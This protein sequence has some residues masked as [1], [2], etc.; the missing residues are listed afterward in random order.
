[1]EIQAFDLLVSFLG[2]GSFAPFSVRSALRF[3]MHN[4]DVPSENFV[5]GG[6][7]KPPI[8]FGLARL[9]DRKPMSARQIRSQTTF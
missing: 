3:G 1:M 2:Y 8:S 4:G 5:R 6:S 7:F 9:Y